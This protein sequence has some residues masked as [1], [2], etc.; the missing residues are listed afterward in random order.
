MKSVSPVKTA[1]AWPSR[2]SSRKHTLPRVWPGV[3]TA[4]NAR[5]AQTNASPSPTRFVTQ[6]VRSA[7][8]AP[9]TISRD[10]VCAARSALP[11]QWS[12]W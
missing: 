9:A 2:A 12:A 8:P 1:G 6:G 7:S 5:P 3:S 4:A 11:P 10:G